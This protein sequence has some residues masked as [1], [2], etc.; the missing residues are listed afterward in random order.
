MMDRH[1]PPGAAA[2][3]RQPHAVRNKKTAPGEAQA[4]FAAPQTLSDIPGL[5]P[6]RVR[7]LQKAGLGSLDAVRA[8]SLE[9]L[10]AV[11]GMSDIKAHH[12]QDYLRR[13]PV[14][15]TPTA[16]MARAKASRKTAAPQTPPLSKARKESA[17]KRAAPAAAPA[18]T[19][20]HTP[21][22]E[23]AQAVGKAIAL[24]TSEQAPQFRSRLLR[25]LARF[26]HRAD[27]LMLEADRLSAKDR[28]RAARRLLRMNEAISAACV[29]RDLD[30]KAQTD[31][32]D[33]LAE[34]S[35]KITLHSMDV[36]SPELGK[37]ADVDCA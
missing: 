31:L 33:R 6:I 21:F 9:V 10:L 18:F 34:T 1:T 23:A 22:P 32:A 26:A 20:T 29:Q 35:D 11:P 3:A 5:G 19:G 14:A 25:E 37:K 17:E 24:L 16:P 27:A 4:P 2:S 12:I 13:F 30:R 8:A 28:A 15:P 36:H 7:A